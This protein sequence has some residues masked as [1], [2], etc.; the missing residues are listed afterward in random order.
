MSAISRTFKYRSPTYD[1]LG[2][3][4]SVLRARMTYRTSAVFMALVDSGASHTFLPESFA[5]MLGIKN[6]GKSLKIRQM[7]GYKGGL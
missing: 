1:D 7:S 4:R 3:L 5:D 6:E 2:T